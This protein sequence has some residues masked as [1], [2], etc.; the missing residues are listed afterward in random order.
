IPIDPR[1][2]LAIVPLLNGEQPMMPAGFMQQQPRNA[3]GNVA[4][5]FNPAFGDQRPGQR[6]FQ[7]NPGGGAPGATPGPMA[8]PPGQGGFN[9][10]RNF[11]GGNTLQYQPHQQQQQQQQPQQQQQQQPPPP[12]PPP[13]QPQHN[14]N[15]S[16]TPSSAGNNRPH[17]YANHGNTPNNAPNQGQNAGNPGP[18]NG[19]H[20]PNARFN[21]HN[22]H[23]KFHRDLDAPDSYPNP[24]SGLSS[25][26]DEFARDMKIVSQGGGSLGSGAGPAGS[27]H[28][29]KKPKVELD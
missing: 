24:R 4:P 2:K 6:P 1:T 17:P 16:N 13:P 14:S 21:K 10:G 15:G 11:P 9:R 18:G 27:G 19:H 23:N 29:R 5:A 26:V 7:Q 22:K 8:G 20:S 3:G 28:M 12:P 25:S